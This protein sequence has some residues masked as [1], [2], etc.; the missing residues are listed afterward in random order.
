MAK[1]ELERAKQLMS[2]LVEGQKVKL[3][4]NGRRI[5]PT[6]TAEDM[7]QPVDYLELDNDPAFRYEEGILD[8]LQ[9]AQMALSALFQ[10]LQLR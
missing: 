3:L 7:L 6:L 1:E 8:G 2:E 10:D 4:E 5:I 9:T